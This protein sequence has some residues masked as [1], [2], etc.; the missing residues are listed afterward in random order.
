MAF[1]I[2][3]NSC[4]AYFKFILGLGDLTAQSYKTQYFTIK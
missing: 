2:G 3:L 4:V 1:H